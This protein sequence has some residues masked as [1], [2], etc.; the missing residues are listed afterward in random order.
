[1]TNT[2]LSRTLAGNIRAEIARRGVTQEE[3]ATRIGMARSSLSH[4][5][6]GRISF[7]VDDLSRIAEALEVE[8]ASL[9]QAPTSS[10]HPDPTNP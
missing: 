1:M 7:D 4:R 9:L 10:D 2:N 6:A 5:L 8:P 3:L